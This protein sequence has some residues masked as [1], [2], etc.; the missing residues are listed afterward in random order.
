MTCGSLV[1]SESN[2]LMAISR[3]N[4]RSVALYT[5]PMPPSPNSASIRKRGPSSSPASNTRDRGPDALALLLCDGECPLGVRTMA[6]AWAFDSARE[7]CVSPRLADSAGLSIVRSSRVVCNGTR[8]SLQRTAVSGFSWPHEGHFM[9]EGLPN[10]RR[11]SNYP[12]RTT[13]RQ[14]ISPLRC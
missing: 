5:R 2:T 14:A 12:V 7:G 4:S 9:V 3:P 10:R 11:K 8:Q 6:G 13:S 1:S